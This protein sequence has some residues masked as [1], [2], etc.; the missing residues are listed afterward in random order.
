MSGSTALRAIFGSLLTL[1][2][3]CAAIPAAAQSGVVGTPIA[4]CVAPARPGDVAATMLRATDR[5]DCTKAQT[6]FGSGNYWVRSGP[7][8]SRAA[9]VRTSSVWQDEATLHIL[10]ADGVILTRHMDG[11]AASRAL[12][13]GAIFEMAIPPRAAPVTRMLWHVRGSANLRGIVVS[14]ALATVKDSARSDLIL[15]TLYGAFAGLCLAL[16]VYNL[17]L[18]AALRHQ[19]QLAYC[20]MV[21]GLLLYT[22]TSSGAVAWVFPAF[23]NNDRLRINYILLAASAASALAFARSFFEREVFQGWL[24]RA[25]SIVTAAL[26]AAPFGVILLAPW[27][28]RLFDGIYASTFLLLIALVPFILW[29]AWRTRSNYLWLFSISWAAPV[30][31]AGVRVAQNFH[32]FGW[33]FLLDNSTIM[34]M[35]LEALIS[36]VAIAYRFRLIAAERDEARERAIAARL[37]ADADPLTGLL[38]R[39]GFLHAAIGRD[40]PHLLVL[41][42]IDHFKAVNETLGHDGGDEVLRIIARALRAAAPPDTLIARLGGEEF[43]MLMPDYGHD[44]ANEVLTR[45]REERMPFDMAVT[46]SLGT[47]AGPINDEAGWKAL[48]RRADQALFAAKAAGRDRVRHAPSAFAA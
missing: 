7:L 3:L 23:E 44:L 18:W 11:H 39:R 42:D 4:V 40:L 26:L 29:N 17:A 25:A 14:P 31:F 10:Y 16:L 8:S 6:S 27:H 24:A 9:Y 34:A 15:G 35:A 38:N 22:F 36:S 2:T 33:H 32:L 45:V 43:A 37:L 20:A 46:I 47:S 28:I 1:L 48:Y 5:Y 41:A 19:F 12:R 13:L 21:A 30:V